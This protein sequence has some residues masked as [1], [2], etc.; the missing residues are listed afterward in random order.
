MLINYTRSRKSHRHIYD[1]IGYG[2]DAVLCSVGRVHGT[3]I[4]DILEK[5]LTV[6]RATLIVTDNRI[7]STGLSQDADSPTWTPLLALRNLIVRARRTR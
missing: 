3:T 2:V 4:H 6:R 5:Q 7:S 1:T